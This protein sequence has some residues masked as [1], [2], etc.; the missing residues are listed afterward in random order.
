[1]AENGKE[2][3]AQITQ[4]KP[5]FAIPFDGPITPFDGHFALVLFAQHV[6]KHPQPSQCSI[7]HEHIIDPNEKTFG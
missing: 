4:T 2:T 6:P 5:T 1:M 3:P 7:V